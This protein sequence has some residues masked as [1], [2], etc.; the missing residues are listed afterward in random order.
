MAV[1][2]ATA[3]MTT[4]QLLALP[5]DGVERWLIRGQLRE[6]PMTYRNRWHSRAMIRVGYVLEAW[7]D[8]Q[9]QPR[10]SVLGGE[11]G[12]RLRHDPDTTVGIDVVYISAELAARDPDDTTIIDGVPVLAVEILSPNNTVEEIDE[13]IEQ[14]LEAGVPL[15]WI[16]NTRHHTVTIHRPDQEP[17]LVN[18]HQ[19]LSGEPHLP[20]FRVPAASLFA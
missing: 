5:D 15:V 11:A 9:P 3:L 19:E 2:E 18:I 4:E 16:L 8:Q 13:K 7:L 1:V 14:Y 17:E 20:G 10:G 6:K 12:V